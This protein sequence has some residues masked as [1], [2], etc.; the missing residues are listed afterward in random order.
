MNS[1]DHNTLIIPS[2]LIMSDGLTAEQEQRVRDNVGDYA[3]RVRVREDLDGDERDAV[4]TELLAM[5]GV[6]ATA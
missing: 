3:D 5:L 2:T 4:A 1:V 6:G